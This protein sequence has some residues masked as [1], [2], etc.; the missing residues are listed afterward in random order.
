MAFFKLNNQLPNLTIQKKYLN[1]NIKFYT[2]SFF[3]IYLN[4]MQITFKSIISTR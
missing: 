4:F 3:V 1:M 2:F